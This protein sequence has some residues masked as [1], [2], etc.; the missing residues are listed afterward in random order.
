MLTN[1]LK[2]KITQNFIE[3]IYYIKYKKI[4]NILIFK[5][6]RLKLIKWIHLMFF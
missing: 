3:N 2:K 6:L 5:W 1:I 4:F